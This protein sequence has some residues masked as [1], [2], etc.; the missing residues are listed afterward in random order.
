MQEIAIDNTPEEIT[1]YVISE[2]SYELYPTNKY[3]KPEY[4]LH[5]GVVLDEGEWIDP[6]IK[7]I[8]KTEEEARKAFEEYETDISGIE[9]GWGVR[10]LRVT[11]YYLHG[12]AFDLGEAIKQVDDI[13][14]EEDFDKQLEEEYWCCKAQEYHDI[15]KEWFLA[16][17]P[18][19]IVV[20]VFDEENRTD[21]EKYVLFHT[22][23]D[24]VEFEDEFL[25]NC[26][27]LKGGWVTKI[28]FNSKNVETIS[29]EEFKDWFKDYNDLGVKEEQ[30]AKCRL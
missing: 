26:D 12:V 24:A 11:E 7:G 3:D 13:N 27:M 23:N 28:Y 20:A 16:V 15:E 9:C 19:D 22:Y 4:Y 25:D 8:Y 1:R 17:S 29:E 18:M 30:E 14:S 6:H 21:T 10:G 5:E 2:I